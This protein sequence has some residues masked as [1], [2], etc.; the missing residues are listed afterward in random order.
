MEEASFRHHAFANRFLK[1]R[2]FWV[3]TIET[4]GSV[5]LV[6]GSAMA[7]TA[8]WDGPER[9]AVPLLL[10]AVASYTFLGI[11][12]LA[13]ISAELSYLRERLLKE[14]ADIDA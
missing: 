1:G 2:G 7:I 12:Y 10:A 11:A 14:R 8:F 9:S 6:V 3:C 13:G 5:F 4:V